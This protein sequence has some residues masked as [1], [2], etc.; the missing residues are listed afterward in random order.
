M[1]GATDG[2]GKLLGQLWPGAWQQVV[3]ASGDAVGPL[4]A[5]H[6]DGAGRQAQTV[7]E[8]VDHGHT[9]QLADFDGDGHLDIYVAE[10]HPPGPGDQ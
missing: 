10:M 1:E 9:L 8:R 6:H 7:I 5:Y 2:L 4:R 3:I